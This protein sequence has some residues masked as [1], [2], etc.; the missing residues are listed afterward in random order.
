MPGCQL[1][2]TQALS[3]INA[4]VEADAMR[5]K[6]G[7]FVKA[8]EEACPLIL[9]PMSRAGDTVLPGGRS[10]RVLPAWPSS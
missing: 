8:S 1:A 4:H 7:E 6:C 10:R 2:N 9:F 5:Q 3:A